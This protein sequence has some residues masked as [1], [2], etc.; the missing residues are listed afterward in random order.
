MEITRYPSPTPT[1]KTQNDSSWN[2]GKISRTLNAE[3]ETAIDL[4]CG[5][6]VMLTGKD[7]PTRVAYFPETDTLKLRSADGRVSV[8]VQHPSPPQME[9]DNETVVFAEAKSYVSL[10]RSGS[11]VV[12]TEPDNPEVAI[13]AA[14]PVPAV[15]PET[16]ARPAAPPP[17]PE[18]SEPASRQ[19]RKEKTPTARVE[20]NVSTDIIYRITS[21]RQKAVAE[22][23]CAEHYTD[24]S[25]TE[26]TVFHKI[27]AFNNERNKLADK[28]RDEAK[29]GD[30]VIARGYWHDVPVRFSSGQTKVER[31][32]WAFAV[33]VTPRGARTE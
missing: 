4:A 13:N 27:A 29:K 17:A 20:G 3:A 25:G 23:V 30:R 24:P 18:R 11:L 1:D 31:Q 22:F 12:M 33:K 16:E 32:L 2:I 5:V 6:G 9:R 28:V 10:S 8:T 15:A 7:S 26:R 21:Q 19:S 14:P